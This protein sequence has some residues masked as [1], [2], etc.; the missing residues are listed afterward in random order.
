MPPDVKSSWKP[1]QVRDESGVATPPVRRGDWV[2]LP[3]VHIS[4]Y[5]FLKAAIVVGMLIEVP[6][7]AARWQRPTLPP[8]PLQRVNAWR[9][10][11]ADAQQRNFSARPRASSLEPDYVP[12]ESFAGARAGYVFQM[13]SQGLGYYRDRSPSAAQPSVQP[14]R[15]WMSMLELR[16]P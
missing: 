6:W 11:N 15:T 7:R 12:A 16:R 10:S 1:Y 3:R 4:N 5:W 9:N 2:A 14:D 13:G 8:T